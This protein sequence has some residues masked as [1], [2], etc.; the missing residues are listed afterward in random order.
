MD[1]RAVFALFTVLIVMPIITAWVAHQIYKLERRKTG[2]E[3]WRD[4]G[5]F[6]LL[7]LAWSVVALALEAALQA[8]LHVDLVSAGGTLGALLLAALSL[9]WLDPRMRRKA[10]II[11]A[12]LLAAIV[13]HAALNL[14]R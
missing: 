1:A 2:A 3:R 11:I 6:A 4:L 7:S 12:G 13:I 5:R 10:T 9:L 14:L 8:I